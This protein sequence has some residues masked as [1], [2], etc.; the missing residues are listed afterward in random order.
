MELLGRSGAASHG[1]DKP[2]SLR[3]HAHAES[4][5]TV[6]GCTRSRVPFSTTV[7]PSTFRGPRGSKEVSFSF[8]QASEVRSVDLHYR[9]SKLKSHRVTRSVLPMPR[10]V[11]EVLSLSRH[12]ASAPSTLFIFELLRYCNIVEFRGST[13]R[14][15][16]RGNS[17]I[18][19]GEEA[20]AWWHPNTK[21]ENLATRRNAAHPAQTGR[22]AER[23]SPGVPTRLYHHG[24]GTVSHVQAKILQNTA[25]RK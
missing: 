19:R 23:L 10:N 11:I 22:S 24:L 21:R 2:L 25:I 8:P 13:V 1:L 16:F 4:T 9:R 18:N 14:S 17:I 15:I 3:H 12:Q 20:L 7:N 5:Y 6:R